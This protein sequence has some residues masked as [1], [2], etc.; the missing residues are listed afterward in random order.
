[1]PACA[2]AI[3]AVTVRPTPRTQVRRAPGSEL[4][5]TMAMMW[6]KYADME[7]PS[8]SRRR[9]ILSMVLGFRPASVAAATSGGSRAAFAA[10]VPRPVSGARLLVPFLPMGPTEMVGTLPATRAQRGMQAASQSSLSDVVARVVARAI[11]AHLGYPLPVERL[12]GGGG[13]RAA[14]VLLDNAS[15]RRALLLVSEAV[16]VHAAVADPAL[17]A[18][19]NRLR[20]VATC[21][22]VPYLLVIRNSEVR[23]APSDKPAPAAMGSP[24]PTSVPTLC[25]IGSAG[26]GGRS[27]ALAQGIAAAGLRIA[28]VQPDAVCRELAFNGGAAALQALVAGQIDAAV[29]P[30]ALVGAWL[31]NGTLIAASLPSVGLPLP[32]AGWFGVMAAPAWSADEIADIGDALAAAFADAR[33]Q[34]FLRRLG[35][36]TLAEPAAALAERI[37]RE[38]SQARRRPG[39]ATLPGP[40]S[41]PIS[42]Q[43][44]K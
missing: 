3:P 1:M 36:L 20:P 9:L 24:A 13:Q 34:E 31:D 2:M 4:H 44:C 39:Q 5:C 42:P 11:E 7:E 8:L 10:T 33:Q 38:Q 28:S 35:L 12:P 6:N 21:I 23:V 30:R 26:Y 14:R 17:A 29:L 27:A 41:R 40:G 25:T 37:C 22:E 15:D 32:P 19:L 43:T 16:C 18:L